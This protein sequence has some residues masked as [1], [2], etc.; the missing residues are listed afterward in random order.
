MRKARVYYRVYIPPDGVKTTC[1]EEYDLDEYTIYSDN[2]TLIVERD[3]SSGEWD[4]R[5]MMIGPGCNWWV[6]FE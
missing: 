4:R 2:G 1:V 5:E 6:S 3:A